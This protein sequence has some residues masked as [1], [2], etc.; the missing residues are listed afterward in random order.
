MSNCGHDNRPGS[1]FCEVCGAAQN[2]V[3]CRC[4]NPCSE[5]AHYCTSCGQP[6]S[7]TMT[8]AVCAAETPS[9]VMLSQVL[10]LL[11]QGAST[12][13]NSSAKVN[14]DDIADMFNAFSKREKKVKKGPISDPD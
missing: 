13:V 6:L 14:Q 3:R 8:S 11:S 10:E 7:E 1:A 4:G 5:L 9:H 2:V 12:A